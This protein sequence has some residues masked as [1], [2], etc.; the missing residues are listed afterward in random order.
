MTK[1]EYAQLVG[2]DDFSELEAAA[3]SVGLTGMQL[4]ER[5]QRSVHGIVD[6]LKREHAL[7]QPGATVVRGNVFHVNFSS[8]SER[9]AIIRRAIPL[10]SEKR[11]LAFMAIAVPSKSPVPCTGQ[12]T[13]I[14]YSAR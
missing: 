12:D 13:V 2:S 4:I 6:D 10:L 3:A 8:P 7:D 9:S 5:M 11:R 1:E 14:P